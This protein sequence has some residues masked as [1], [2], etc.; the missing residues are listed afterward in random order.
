MFFQV[1][2]FS[3]FCLLFGTIL[4]SSCANMGPRMSLD[5][6]EGAWEF[7]E[8][9]GTT[10]DSAFVKTMEWV[11]LNFKSANSVVQLQDKASGKIVLQAVV[12]FINVINYSYCNYSLAMTIKDKKMKFVYSLGEIRPEINGPHGGYPPSSEMP[13]IEESFKA[14]KDSIVAHIKST[15]SDDF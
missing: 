10:Q 6:G 13:V 3:A 14:T 5:P 12:P 15:K 8:T 1:K 11:A 4:F 9:H 2:I 7:V